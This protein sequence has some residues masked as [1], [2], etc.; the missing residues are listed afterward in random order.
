MGEKPQLKA[1]A[2]GTSLKRVGKKTREQNQGMEG[3]KPS[4]NKNKE[5]RDSATYRAPGSAALLLPAG[6]VGGL[7]LLH[8]QPAA[9]A[10]IQPGQLEVP[11]SR[12][13]TQHPTAPSPS[14]S[15]MPH[16]QCPFVLTVGSVWVRGGQRQRQAGRG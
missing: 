6:P 1:Q 8:L 15:A 2:A 3:T 9:A 13:S 7:L 4:L 11:A 10:L 5:G 14:Q 16:L 12:T